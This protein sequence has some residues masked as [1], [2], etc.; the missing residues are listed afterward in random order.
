MGFAYQ[1]PALPGG[2]R[3]E[4][5]ENRAYREA[6]PVDARHRRR[7]ADAAVPRRRGRHRPDSAVRADGGDA[8]EGRRRGALRHACRA[9]STA[10]ISSSG[11][12]IHG[13]PTT[14]GAA[15]SGS[16]RTS[17]HATRLRRRCGDSARDPSR[18]RRRTA[19]R[20]RPTST[21]AANARSCSRTAAASIDRSWQP[22]AEA[23]DRGR[24]PGRGDRLSSRPWS[25][26]RP[27]DAVR[28]R[29][30]LPGQGC[31]R[32]RALSARIGGQDRRAS[33]APASAAA[34]RRRRRSTPPGAI[35]RVVLIAH[36]TVDRP[37]KL[38]DAGAVHPR[39]RRRQRQRSAPARDPRAVPEGARDRRNWCCSTARAHAQFLFATPQGERLMREILRFVSRLA[40]PI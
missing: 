26:G 19:A 40:A 17:K 34:P 1:D 15:V 4:D 3:P 16:T 25:A 8:E 2:A 14:S 31:A 6:S 38:R 20:S 28:L 36:M 7:R 37:E 10:P 33:S 12:A 29:R 32:R 39:P 18:F 35:N 23:L 5:P 11:P 27:R 22:Q 13:C 21:A 30:G 9:A 24:L